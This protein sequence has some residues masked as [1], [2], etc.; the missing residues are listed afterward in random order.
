ME[1]ILNKDIKKLGNKDD[2]LTVKNGYGRNYLIPKG[3]AILAT[4][5]AKKANSSSASLN[6]LDSI[7]PSI[8]I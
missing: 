7:C 1:I 3:F 5:S 4:S 6:T 2:I 8:S